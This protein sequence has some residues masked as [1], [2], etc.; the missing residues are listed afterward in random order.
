MCANVQKSV[1]GVLAVPHNADVCQKFGLY[2]SVCC[3]AE[4]VLNAG[5]LFPDCPKHPKLTTIWKPVVDEKIARLTGKKPESD[6]A[7][8]PETHIENRRLF[9]VALGRRKLE[10]WEQNHL[11]ACTVCQGVLYVFVHQPLS[12]VPEDPGKRGDANDARRMA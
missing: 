7:L 10:E 6:P 8:A 9:D 3:G 1:W 12:A 2:K 11:H 5:S 4:I